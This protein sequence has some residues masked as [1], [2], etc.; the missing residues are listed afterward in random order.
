MQ[1]LIRK[2]PKKPGIYFFKNKANQIIYIGK[3]KSIQNR[4]RSYFSSIHRKDPKTQVLIKNIAHI[5]Y[6]VVRSEGEALLTEAN[7]IKQH[8][9]RY[10]VY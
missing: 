4:V 8:K 10:N 7:L 6:L 2:I 3:A 9:P 1:D 5:D